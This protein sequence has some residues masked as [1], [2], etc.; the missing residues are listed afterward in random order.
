MSRPLSATAQTHGPTPPL[1]ARLS[2]AMVALAVPMHSRSYRRTFSEK[3][4]GSKG[5]NTWE[6]GEQYAE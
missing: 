1:L 4:G 3:L 2:V 6:K 5:E